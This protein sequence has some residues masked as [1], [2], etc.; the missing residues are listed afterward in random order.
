MTDPFPACRQA[1][2]W[3][4]F[5]SRPYRTVRSGGGYFFL[6]EKKVT[7]GKIECKGNSDLQK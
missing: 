3:L 5:F 4:A 7:K 6:P 2:N 1:G